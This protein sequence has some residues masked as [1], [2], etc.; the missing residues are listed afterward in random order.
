MYHN[1]LRIADIQINMHIPEGCLAV[2]AGLNVGIGGLCMVP[3]VI[4][5]TTVTRGTSVTGGRQ[6]TLLMP[7]TQEYASGHGFSRQSS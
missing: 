1:E 4:F 5:M 7:S 6:L 2:G 3:R